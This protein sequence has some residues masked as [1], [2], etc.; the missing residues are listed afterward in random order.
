MQSFQTTLTLCT[1][2]LG[3]KKNCSS[4]TVTLLPP[5][6]KLRKLQHSFNHTFGSLNEWFSWDR[7]E[8]PWKGNGSGDV[9]FLSSLKIDIPTAVCVSWCRGCG[10]FMQ[11][12]LWG[13][14]SFLSWASLCKALEKKVS[15]I[16]TQSARQTQHAQ[17]TSLKNFLSYWVFFSS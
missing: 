3:E 15:N 9:V 6:L 2:A 1:P 16:Q 8:F 17:S 7:K 10:H 14:S 12:V 5:I 11:K 13:M 4:N